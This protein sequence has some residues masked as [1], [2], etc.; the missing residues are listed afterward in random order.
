MRKY[1]IIP[2][3]ILGVVLIAIGAVYQFYIKERSEAFRQNEQRREQLSARLQG[4]ANTFA[5]KDGRP[6]KPEEA[7]KQYRLAVQPWNDKLRSFSTIYTMDDDFDFER[8]PEN[9]IPKFHYR[10]TFQEMQDELLD[11]AWQKSDISG[12]DI[13]FGLV[14][15]DSLSGKNPTAADVNGWLQDYAFNIAMTKRAIDSGAWVIRRVSIWPTREE[16]QLLELRTIGYDMDIPLNDLVSF[17]REFYDRDEYVAIDAI[18][19]TNSN[20][21]TPNE[22]LLTV[23]ILVTQAKFQEGANVAWDQS[24]AGDESEELKMLQQQAGGFTFSGIGRG[25]DEEEVEE[26]GSWRRWLRRFLPL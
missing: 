2:I 14:L 13:T 5:G 16:L 26:T 10:D 25:G 22:P 24:A 4:L 19:I 6:V 20:L 1:Q 17:L 7:V 11:Y 3:A 9:T 12:I 15:P 8:V 23:K 18:R 21:L